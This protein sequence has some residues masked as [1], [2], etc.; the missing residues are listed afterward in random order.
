MKRKINEAAI[1]IKLER[2]YTKDKILEMYLNTIYL[3]SGTYGVEKASQ[4]YF[5]TSAKDL[6]LPQ[7]A[8][9]A[10][11]VRAPESYSPFNNIEKATSRRNLVLRL[12]HEQGFIESNQYLEVIASPVVLSEYGLKDN[13]D[14]SDRIAPYFVDY[15]KEI[16][17]M[18]KFTDYDVFKG[19]L[20]IYT[21]L[22]LDLQNKA[23]EA[24]KTVFPQE[25]GP[26]YALISMNPGNDYIH[27][28]IGGKD[29]SESKFNIAI[30]GKRQPG[31]I[32]KTMVLMESLNQNLS[33]NTKYNPNGPITIDMPSDPDWV[34]DNYGGK[35]YEDEM[36]VVD[37]TIYSVN[38]VYA[39]LMMKVG[40]DNVDRLCSQ[41]EISDIGNNP[42]I[43][44]GGLEFGITPLDVCKAF[45]TLASG[46]H[47][48]EPVAIL[49]IADSAD[50]ILYEYDNQEN[51]SN[52]EILEEPVAY[53][54]T[55]ILKRVI[56]EGTGK[57]ANIGVG[58]WLEK[59][60]LLPTMQRPGLVVILQSLPQWSGWAIK[61]QAGRWNP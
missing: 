45:S 50:N 3:G 37:A 34:V 35:K 48:Y 57:G 10:G 1:S 22:D 42:T 2:H 54:I 23:E 25:I 19:G 20:K 39:Q 41:M 24:I 13:L 36:S 17:Y 21:T 40:A 18:K 61:I 14:Y 26:S 4:V 43:A 16:L 11:L 12:M 9:L 15:I 6:T 33:P 56:T 53:Y 49:K 46:G 27:A 29:Y 51:E 59:L 47:Y 52:K 58:Q 44:L 8:L 38:V 31:S 30:Q 7:A 55:Q 5:G 60:V 32:F 28:L